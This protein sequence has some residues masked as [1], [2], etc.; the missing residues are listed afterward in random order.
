MGIDRIGKGGPVAP[1]AGPEKAEQT[2]RT[3]RTFEIDPT[4][5]AAHATSVE[6][7]RAT[8]PLA[9]LRAGQIDLDRYLDLKV[10]DATRHLHGLRVAELD[11]IK[12]TLRDQLASDPA[13]ADLV[14][15]ATGSVP[16]SPE[17]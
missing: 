2:E 8:T 3:G 11:A 5:K 12:K 7:A 16:Q 10:E 4:G 15:Q 17:E 13:L 9:Q 6:G 14:K 1:P